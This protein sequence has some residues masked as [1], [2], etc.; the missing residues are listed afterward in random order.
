MS[1]ASFDIQ[2]SWKI[3]RDA[4]FVISEIQFAWRDDQEESVISAGKL[5]R[6]DGT[7]LLGNCIS[8]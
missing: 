5:N 8:M 7:N 6:M 4:S 3:G 1:P 2:Y